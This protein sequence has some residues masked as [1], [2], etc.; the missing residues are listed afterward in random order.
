MS[1]VERQQAPQGGNTATETVNN[2]AVTKN[3]TPET[4]FDPSNQY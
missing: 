1:R 2:S 4:V 3:Q